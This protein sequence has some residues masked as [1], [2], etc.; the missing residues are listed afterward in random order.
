VH[1]PQGRRL[2]PR[3]AA[4]AAAVPSGSR[5]ADVGADHGLLPLWLARTGRAAFCLATEKDG[6][7]LARVARPPRDAPWAERLAY[8]AGDGLT[9]LRRSDRVDTVVLAGLGARTILHILAAP[10]APRRGVVRLILQPRTDEAAVR[11]W[12][13]IHGWR[14]VSERLTLE[15]SRFHLTLAAERGDDEAAY[16]H[17]T[18]HRSDLLAAGPLLVRARPTALV[19]AWREQHNRLE[20]IVGRGGSGAAMARAE[21]ELARARRI[22]EAISTPAG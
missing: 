10:D 3:L 6:A 22:L 18:L 7:R 19:R 1:E 17:P 13:S 16:R 11:R 15:R 8:R 14:P 21:R 5:V 12:L 2:P 20:A 4:V 9:A